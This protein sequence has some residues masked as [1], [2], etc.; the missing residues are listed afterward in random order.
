[1][2]HPCVTFRNGRRFFFT[3]TRGYVL[4]RIPAQQLTEDN[5]LA[6]AMWL[7]RRGRLDEADTLLEDYCDGR[8]T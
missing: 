8:L 1:M 4:C 6:L 7:A 2:P 3:W 5:V